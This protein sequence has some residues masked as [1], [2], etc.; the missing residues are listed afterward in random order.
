[1]YLQSMLD[2]VLIACQAWQAGAEGLSV[3][4]DLSSEQAV[5]RQQG[6]RPQPTHT[7]LAGS[8]QHIAHRTPRKK[9][10][11]ECNLTEGL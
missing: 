11:E 1:M 10:K 4:R 2:L 7:V 5:F 8:Q 9:K 3:L 6:L